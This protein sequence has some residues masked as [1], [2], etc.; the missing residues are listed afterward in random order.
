MKWSKAKETPIAGLL[1]RLELTKGKPNWGYQ[2]RF[3]LI[4]ISAHNMAAIAR[5]MGAKV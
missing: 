5:A 4:E 3:G 2:L 1:G